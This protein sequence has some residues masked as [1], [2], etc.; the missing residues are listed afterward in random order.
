MKKIIFVLIGFIVI[1][2]LS[3]PVLACE[4]CPQNINLNFEQTAQKADLVIIG[5]KV[6]DGPSTKV[7]GSQFPGGPEWIKVKVLE[8]LKGNTQ[9]KEIQVKSWYGMCAYGIILNDNK[10]HVIFLQ[11]GKDQYY[12]V[13]SGCAI[14]TFSVDG[15]IVN[16]QETELSK[17]TQKISIDKLVKKIGPSA[18]RKKITD[19]DSNETI[20]QIRSPI[21]YIFITL[22]IIIFGFLVLLILTIVIL[23]LKDK[24]KKSGSKNK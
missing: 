14:R 15:N 21:Y 10:S 11:N 8:I 7:H 12:A 17:D 22:A 3:M 5:Q 20:N 6:A 16:F 24:S 19:Y 23:V 2:L 13:N 18:S 9:D 1:S 4:P